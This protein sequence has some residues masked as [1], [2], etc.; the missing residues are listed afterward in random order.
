[1]VLSIRI[2][3]FPF[4]SRDESEAESSKVEFDV[5]SNRL[6]FSLSETPIFLSS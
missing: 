1:M 5:V 6:P 3:T 2:Y 4:S